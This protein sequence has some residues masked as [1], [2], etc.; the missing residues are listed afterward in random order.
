MQTG[1]KLEANE[2]KEQTTPTTSKS[3]NLGHLS[4]IDGVKAITM[5]SVIMGH[6]LTCSPSILNNGKELVTY[7]GFAFFVSHLMPA[8][9]VNS[10][11]TITGLLTCYLMFKENQTYLLVTSLFRLVALI[12]YHCIVQETETG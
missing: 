8:F 11:F 2:I 4:C 9:S 12:A 3:E 1:K 7:G 6:V 10:S 5:T